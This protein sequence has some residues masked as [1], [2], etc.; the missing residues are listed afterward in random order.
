MTAT[1]ALVFVLGVPLA[2]G[3]EPGHQLAALSLSRK[4]PPLLLGLTFTLGLALADGWG[5]AGQVN[6]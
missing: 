5:A 1:L 6:G 2:A 3:M 4:L